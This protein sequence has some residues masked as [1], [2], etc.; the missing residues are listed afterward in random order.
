MSARHEATEVNVD[1]HLNGAAGNGLIA[2]EASLVHSPA[3]VAATSSHSE[4]ATVAAG[5][6]RS[7]QQTDEFFVLGS[8]NSDTPSQKDSHSEGQ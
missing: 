4:G 5:S 8:F 6:A 1:G 2:E 3:N 7:V